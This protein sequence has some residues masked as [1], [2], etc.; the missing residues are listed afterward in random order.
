MK[1]SAY[2][3]DRD[4]QQ[5]MDQHQ[6][7][8]EDVQ[9][10]FGRDAY[11]AYQEGLFGGGDELWPGCDDVD[12]EAL[13]AELAHLVALGLVPGSKSAHMGQR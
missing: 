9:D 8:A 2:K 4:F 13:E 12:V 3:V 10:R 11:H 1:K 6:Q 7:L 5:A